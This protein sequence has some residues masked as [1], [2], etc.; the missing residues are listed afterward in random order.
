MKTMITVSAQTYTGA[1]LIFGIPGF[2]WWLWISSTSAALAVIA[3]SS[4]RGQENFPPKSVLSYMDRTCPK[5]CSVFK[6]LRFAFGV[7][8]LW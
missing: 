3:N 2:V 5:T 1:G 4:W 7:S 8:L 6:M